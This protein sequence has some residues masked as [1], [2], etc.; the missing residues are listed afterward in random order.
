MKIKSKFFSSITELIYEKDSVRKKHQE[1]KEREEVVADFYN[2]KP[3]MSEA[4]ADESQLGDIT[5]HLLGYQSMQQIETRLYSIWSTSNKLIDVNITEGEDADQIERDTDLVNEYLNRAIYSTP[6]FGNFWRAVCGELALHGRAAC[7]YKDDNDWC[8]AVEP[9]LMLPDSAGSQASEVPYAFLPRD[10]SIS[11]LKHLMEH[12]DDKKEELTDKEREIDAVFGGGYK[13]NSKAIQTLIDTIEENIKSDNNDSNPDRD[14][15]RRKRT[16]TDEVDRGDKTTLLVWYYY[17]LRFDEEAEQT[18]V[19]VTVFTDTPNASGSEPNHKILAYLPGFYERPEAWMHL[20]TMDASIG[21]NKLFSTAKGIAEISYNSD[22]DA[23]ELFNQLIEGE[24]IRAIPRMQETEA[25]NTEELLG[26]DLHNDT[27]VPKSLTP[28]RLEGSSN[29]AGALN[30]MQRN[31]SSITGSGISNTGR[32][33]ELRQQAVERQSNNAATQ[34]SRTSD[35]FK[36]LDILCQEVYLKFCIHDVTDGGPGSQQVKWF[37]YK[38]KKLGVD[39]ET[40]AERKFGFFENVK[41]RAVRSSSS[42]END[43]DFRTAQLL[44]DNLGN[45]PAAVRPIIIRRLTT[46]ITH[47]PEFAD[48][49]TE[50]LP[51]IQSAQRVTAESEFEQI[52]RDASLGLETPI[53]ADDI[54]QEHAATHIKHLMVIVQRAE[55]QP[56]T[57]QDATHFG[58]MQLHTQLHLDELLQN[59]TTVAEGQ[60][61]LQQFNQIVSTADG[62][63]ADLNAREE[64]EAR[65]GAVNAAE[66][67]LQLKEREQARKEADTQSTIDQ[68]EQRQNGIDRKADQDFT[69]RASKEQREAAAQKATVGS[70]LSP[71]DNQ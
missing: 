47:D 63:L 18:V 21:G 13:I 3:I 26:W 19:D 45:Y 7:L 62:L 38:M 27:L 46:L 25:S 8:P 4:E 33:Q 42:G 23:E 16:D 44:M 5:N 55:F 28:V 57:R 56:W 48:R 22:I 31:S 65:G 68:R 34:T 10:M 50:V 17:E 71:L 64:E 9:M 20:I 14:K 53:G 52:A 70:Q 2:G 51:K 49:L 54:H 36:N 59:N 24:K 1:R 15:S 6:R 40:L 37:R 41:V 30:L 61:L 66:R 58:G 39:I 12:A 60:A 32:G 43:E 69:L 35:I 11:D 29:L 67:E